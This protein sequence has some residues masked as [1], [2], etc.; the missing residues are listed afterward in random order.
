M[1]YVETQWE[2][3]LDACKFIIV[4]IGMPNVEN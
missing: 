4:L 1:I 2:Q 3:R